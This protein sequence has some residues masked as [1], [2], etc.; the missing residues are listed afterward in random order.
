MRHGIELSISTIIL[1]VLGLLVL[2]IVLYLVASNANRANNAVSSCTGKGGQCVDVGE[3][4]PQGTQSIG[5]FFTK[6]CSEGQRCCA[7]ALS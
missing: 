1:I 5:S 7:P 3:P 6:E 4:C 2:A